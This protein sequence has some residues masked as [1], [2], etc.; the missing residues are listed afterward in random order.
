MA[1][2]RVSNDHLIV[3]FKIVVELEIL[4]QLSSK[5]WSAGEFQ[6]VQKDLSL[7]MVCV[8]VMGSLRSFPTTLK[9]I[10]LMPISSDKSC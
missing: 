6:V 2:K 7:E 5:S 1:A 4:R 3:S 8:T 9:N 10:R